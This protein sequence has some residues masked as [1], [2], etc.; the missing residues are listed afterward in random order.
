MS[1]PAKKPHTGRRKKKKW[2]PKK[3]Q[4]K[5]T[6][7]SV[8]LEFIEARAKRAVAQGFEVPK[9]LFFARLMIEDGL[10]VTMY[11]ARHTVSKYLSVHK[12]GHKSYKVRFSNHKPIPHRELAGDCDFFVGRTNLTITTTAMAIAAVRKHFGGSR[13]PTINET[14]RSPQEELDNTPSE[15]FVL[16]GSL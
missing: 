11:E 15:G 12:E 1:S 3:W 6:D 9:Y 4:Q 10:R 8:T 16:S 13:V 7:G 2:K 5:V 14:T